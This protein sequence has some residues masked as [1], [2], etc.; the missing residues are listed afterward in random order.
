MAKLLLVVEW[1][2]DVEAR[3]ELLDFRS[4]ERR[5]PR[6]VEQGAGRGEKCKE[7]S[8]SPLRKRGRN[9]R[10]EGCH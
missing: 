4:V 6:L 7:S 2:R 1:N 9:D 5:L 3:P 8:K 10:L